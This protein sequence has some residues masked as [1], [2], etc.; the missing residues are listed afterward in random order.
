MVRRD[1]RLGAQEGLTVPDAATIAI[2]SYRTSVQFGEVALPHLCRP[3]TVSSH[4]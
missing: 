3:P 4:W 1:Q 2:K